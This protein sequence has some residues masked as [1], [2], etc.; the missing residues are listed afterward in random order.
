MIN[1]K[2]N[3]QLIVDV[4]ALLAVKDPSGYFSKQKTNAQL[5]EDVNSLLGIDPSEYQ[6][7]G[8]KTNAQLSADVNTLL[9]DNVD[10]NVGHNIDPSDNFNVDYNVNHNVNPSD[11]FVSKTHRVSKTRHP[12]NQ[13]LDYNDDL[14]HPLNV[15]VDPSAY[16]RDTDNSIYKRDPN[17]AST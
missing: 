9:G 17:I 4:N 3:A 5:T 10:Y 6:F 14:N 11:N 12:V 16:G 7:I 2:T 13:N 8:E 15:N 1:E